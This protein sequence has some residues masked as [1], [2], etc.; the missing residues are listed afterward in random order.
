MMSLPVLF[1]STDLDSDH[2]GSTNLF[3]PLN[4]NC[5]VCVGKSC[6]LKG[7]LLCW[8]SPEPH[9][10]YRGILGQPRSDMSGSRKDVSFDIAHSDLIFDCEIF[11][12]GFPGCCNIMN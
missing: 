2:P 3:A 1:L 9:C 5:R 8:K 11:S 7:R 6:S 10:T 4:K 12:V